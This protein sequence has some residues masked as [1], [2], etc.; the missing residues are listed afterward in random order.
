MELPEVI[1]YP[2]SDW[3]NLPHIVT[4]LVYYIGEYID[5]V[6]FFTGLYTL[7]NNRLLYLLF[8]L[9]FVL[10]IIFNYILKKIIR[11]RRPCINAHLFDLLMKNNKE[12]VKR[13]DIPYHIYGMP[14]GRS[15]LCG[16]VFV[17]LT[18]FLRDNF[19]SLVYLLICIITMLQRV[20]YEHNTILQVTVGVFIGCL[21]GVIMYFFSK[22][23]IAGNLMTKK[24]DNCY[25]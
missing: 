7:R 24:D 5:S 10:C 1:I 16:F 21:F 15:Q 9:G 11:I 22:N 12:Y 6:L 8:C 4:N 17:Y 18:L 20:K 19:I 3:T 25:L 14:S 23:I 13:N 2:I